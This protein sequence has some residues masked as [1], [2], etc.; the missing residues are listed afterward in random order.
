MSLAE[1]P[2]PRLC[3][4][5]EV[6]LWFDPQAHAYYRQG[7][8]IGSV[9]DVLKAVGII[10]QN[11]MWVTEHEMWKGTCI[12]KGVELL[13]KGT[14]DWDT[15][16]DTEIMPYLQSYEKFIQSTGFKARRIEYALVDIVLGI[17]GRLDIE[18]LFPSGQPAVIDVKTGTV[19][20]FTRIQLS[21]YDYLLQSED[22]TDKPRERYALELKGDR[23]RIV[24]FG[25]DEHDR[26]IFLSACS[27]FNWRFN[28]HGHR[29]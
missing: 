22:K 8:R 24:R 18:G 27:I 12:H 10:D 6:D 7:R 16:D 1:Q 26:G 20:P 28:K 11:E 3:L 15:V 17:A 23:P 13:N 25:D 2:N 21:G 9:T 14:L 5:P 19:K 4:K 29:K